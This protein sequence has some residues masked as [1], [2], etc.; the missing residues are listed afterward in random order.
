MTNSFIGTGNVENNS[1][2][3]QDRREIAASQHRE[4]LVTKDGSHTILVPS[5]DI[6][7]RS[8][9]GAIQESLHVFIDAGLKYKWSTDKRWSG[10]S[11]EMMHIFEVGFGTGLNAL[12][13]AIE[14]IAVR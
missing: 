10:D 12:L 2:I 4:L 14:S 8:R 7:Y 3:H 6:T 11:E 5:L 1:S 9:H 13:T